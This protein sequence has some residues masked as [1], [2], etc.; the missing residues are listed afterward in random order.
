MPEMRGSICSPLCD[1]G[2]RDGCEVQRRTTWPPTRSPRHGCGSARR[3]ASRSTGGGPS[4]WQETSSSCE[5]AQIGGPGRCR[6]PSGPVWRRAATRACRP[7]PRRRTGGGGQ[8]PGASHTSLPH[9]PSAAHRRATARRTLPARGCRDR[10]D[11][12]PRRSTPAGGRKGASRCVGFGQN[13]CS[14]PDRGKM[15]PPV[16][17]QRVVAGAG[18]TVVKRDHPPTETQRCRS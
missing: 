4:P 10:G 7:R 12:R 8:P 1:P 5:R 13:S 17:D 16:A 15:G 18:P 11:R 9:L 14:A 2:W 3:R 6:I